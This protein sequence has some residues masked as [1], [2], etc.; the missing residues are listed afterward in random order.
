MILKQDY[1]VKLNNKNKIQELVVSL[2]YHPYED[3]YSIQRSF[4]QRGGKE[5]DI[6]LFRIL[7]KARNIE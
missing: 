6:P 4:G 3:V 5:I 7:R 2:N 1:L